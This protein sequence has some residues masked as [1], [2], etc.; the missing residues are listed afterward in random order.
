[1]TA[2]AVK[3]GLGVQHPLVTVQPLV[4][5]GGLQ[6]DADQGKHLLLRGPEQGGNLDLVDEVGGEK[7]LADQQHADAG[8]GQGLVDVPLPARADLGVVVAPN[9]KVAVAL[10]GLEILAQVPKPLLVAMAVAD[11]DLVPR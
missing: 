3:W 11:E 7:V 4:R 5:G 9:R 1:M 2:P 8:A 10:V 6:G